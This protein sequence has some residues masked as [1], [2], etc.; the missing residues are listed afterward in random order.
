MIK[1]KKHINLIKALLLIVISTGFLSYFS[2]NE[3]VIKKHNPNQ[4]FSSLSFD[5]FFDF[6]Q[7]TEPMAGIIEKS[8]AFLLSLPLKKS[9]RFLNQVGF[10]DSCQGSTLALLHIGSKS[11]FKIVKK[12]VSFID[13]YS[14]Y[15]QLRI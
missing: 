12:Q 8:E 11:N 9:G 10:N 4:E 7:P 14:T 5:T 3:A 2:F 6:D 13:F 1:Q 15:R